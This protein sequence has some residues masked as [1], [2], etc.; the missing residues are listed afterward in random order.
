VSYQFCSTQNYGKKPF[1]LGIFLLAPPS[2]TQY[3]GGPILGDL[4]WHK[5]IK[6]VKKTTPVKLLSLQTL[7]D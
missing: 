3:P 6:I 7:A 1:S 2:L 5:E 4:S